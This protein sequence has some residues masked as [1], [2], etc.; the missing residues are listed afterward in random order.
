MNIGNLVIYKEKAALIAAVGKDKIDIRTCE[1]DSRS[2]RLKDIEILHPGPVS[3]LNFPPAPQVDWQELGE[4]ADENVPLKE[5]QNFAQF[6]QA[7]K[8]SGIR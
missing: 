8:E 2:V 3:A 7:Q 6:E 5:Y 1:G 4:L